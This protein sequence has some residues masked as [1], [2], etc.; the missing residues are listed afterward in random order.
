MVL[1]LDFGVERGLG[2]RYGRL[3]E[4]MREL[5]GCSVVI[6]IAT[7]Y[8]LLSLYV[9]RSAGKRQQPRLEHESLQTQEVQRPGLLRTWKPG[10][11]KKKNEH[12][13]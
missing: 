9:Q 6:I 11:R 1:G 13:D 10:L 4:K 12:L 3:G 2:E 8:L 7:R 5:M